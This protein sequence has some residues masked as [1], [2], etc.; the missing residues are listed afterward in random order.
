MEHI[1]VGV[2]GSEGSDA[3]LRWAVAEARAHGARLEVVLAW[4]YLDQP[5]VEFDPDYGEPVARAA[6][7]LVIERAGPTDDLEVVRTCVNDL[8]ARALLAASQTADLVVVGSR[9][10]GAFKGMVL[11][12]VSQQVVTRA[13]CSVLV[14]RTESDAPA[15]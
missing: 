1:V 10:L 4:S 2:D 11:G 6:L 14:V 9:G 7:D 8:P 12:S 13:A 5:T 3:A 15:S